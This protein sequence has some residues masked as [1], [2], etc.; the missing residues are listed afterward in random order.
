MNKSISSSISAFISLSIS[1]YICKSINLPLPINLSFS[2]HITI[3]ISIYLHLLSIGIYISITSRIVSIYMLSL[4]DHLFSHP[5]T[6]LSVYGIRQC[7]LIYVAIY[8]SLHVHVY[9]VACNDLLPIDHL[10]IHLRSSTY[11]TPLPHPSPPPPLKPNN[12]SILPRF[13][14]HSLIHLSI[15]PSI[16]SC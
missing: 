8:S 2:I 9:R 15:H 6:S 3:S 12:P 1:P 7:L 10:S 14:I 4:I 5:S 13:S 11:S 16:F